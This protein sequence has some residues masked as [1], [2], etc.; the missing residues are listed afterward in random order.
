MDIHLF[1]RALSFGAPCH[2]EGEATAP[3]WRRKP[4]PLETYFDR[5]VEGPAAA[6]R[7]SN[8][9]RISGRTRMTLP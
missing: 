8:N 1:N 4:N 3:N 6:K 2:K 9:S 5:H 7:R